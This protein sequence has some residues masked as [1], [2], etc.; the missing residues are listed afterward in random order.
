M[1]PTK[2]PVSKR[3]VETLRG[4]LDALPIEQRCAVAAY[5]NGTPEKDAAAIAGMGAIEFRELRWHVKAKFASRI[6]RPVASLGDLL[7]RQ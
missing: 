4:V 6:L 2:K 7:F 1:S 3:D 5:Y